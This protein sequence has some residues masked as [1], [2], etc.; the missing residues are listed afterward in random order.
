MLKIDIEN[1]R[2]EIDALYTVIRKLSSIPS[3]YDDM[4]KINWEIEELKKLTPKHF[5]DH[6][7]YYARFYIQEYDCLECGGNT[8]EITNKIYPCKYCTQRLIANPIDEPLDLDNNPYWQVC[9][10][11]MG[12]Q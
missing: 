5:C 7:H 4:R 9:N 2:K 12:I 6:L 3:A 1:R 11:C 8:Q 10:A